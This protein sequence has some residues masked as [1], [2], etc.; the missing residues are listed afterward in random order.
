LHQV[1]KIS[2]AVCLLLY[3]HLASAQQLNFDYYN[4]SNGLVNNEVHCIIQAANGSMYAGT[5]GGLSIFDGTSFNNYDVNK[6]FKHSFISG[7]RELRNE[8]TV[9]FTNETQY[10]SIK[11]RRLT[12]NSTP[13]KKAI[14][15]IFPS[16]SHGWYACTYSGLFIFNNGKL[17]KLPV[18][19]GKSFPGINF[20]AECQDSLLIIGRSYESLDVYNIHTWKLIASSTDKLFVRDI[21]VDNKGNI[22]VATIGS[23]PR[24]FSPADIRNKVINFK[25]LPAQ[26]DPFLHT[27]FRSIVYDKENCI[28]MGMVNNGVIKYNPSTN[29]FKH[30]TIEQGLASNTVFSLYCDKEDNLWIGTNRGLQKLAHNYVTSYSSKQGLPAD[31]ALDVAPLPGGRALVCG[32][33]GVGYVRGVGQKTKAWT[34]PLADEYFSKFD[35]LKKEWF[36]LSLKK[37][38]SLNISDK[39]ISAK[40]IYPLPEHFRSMVAFQNDKLILGGDSTILLFS[41]GKL[42]PLTKNRVHH[43]SCM[44][45]G[46]SGILW[47][48]CL[49]NTING[50]YLQLND[51]NAPASLK[52]HSL[53]TTVGPQDYIQCI[54]ADKKNRLL[55][56][57]SQ[58]GITIWEQKNHELTQFARINTSS[59][60]SNNNILA[61]TWHNDSTLLVATGYG[62]DKITFHAAGGFSVRNVNDYYNFSSTV[63]SIRKDESGN[64]LLGTELG[65]LKLPSVDIEQNVDV[66]RQISIS[67]IQL[68]SNPDSIIDVKKT[69]VLPY[70]N[71]GITLSYSSPSFINEKNTRYVYLLSGGSENKWSQPSASNHITLLNLSPGHYR[72]MVKAENMYGEI[73][74]LVAAVEIVIHPAFWQTWWF[75]LLLICAIAIAIYL[76]VT[77]RIARIRYE[78]SL[79][80]KIA[81]T[82][83]MALR[84]QMNP[85][86]IF[87]CMNIIDGLITGN[88]RGEA[89]AFLQNFSKLIRLVLENS[90]YQEVPIQQDIQALRLYAELEVIR[91]N[92]SFKFKFDIDKELIAENYEIPPL[93]LQ[94]YVENAIV[95]GLRNKDNEAGY[96]YV[97]V[98]KNGDKVS[99]II[100][101]NGVGRKKAMQL[102][103]E[104]QRSHHSLGMKVTAK[105][106][107]LLQMINQ[108]KLGIVVTDVGV[109]DDT[110]TRVVITLP[111]NLRFN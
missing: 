56:G 7:L 11:G 58:G 97:G 103:D 44:T 37:L 49:N 36:G 79:K 16:K 91:C 8:E 105:R 34:P 108:N 82:E 101:D 100:E 17:T 15:N 24:V 48:A 95:H 110:G 83:M 78:S 80:H 104:N 9:L 61:L 77:K 12:L 81:E 67:A 111:L 74:P 26:F 50:Y 40:K 27:E 84:A 41:K 75:G 46:P 31:L 28:W 19:A 32:Y 52:F 86:F 55:C 45:I 72:F 51:N 87:N 33:S 63:Y 68:L 60:L 62:L 42:K 13:Q 107:D 47:T 2:I 20:V 23:G 99:A 21:C 96:L 54:A 69:I 102:K 106:I 30:F 3:C 59:G 85:H 76:V 4:K 5:P 14:K 64:I 92:H 71:N 65:F 89:Q 57:A 93:L 39:S 38:I 10:Y 94:P 18:N 25:K 22:W 1:R 53:A 6:G 90:Q 29:E 66:K 70:D 88:R 109:G 73:S 98:K 43:I 35:V